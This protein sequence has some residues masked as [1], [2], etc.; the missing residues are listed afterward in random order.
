MT[1]QQLVAGK[2]SE[3]ETAASGG[4]ALREDRALRGDRALHGD[5][6]TNGDIVLHVRTAAHWQVLRSPYR[7]RIFEAVRS[8]G[9]CCIKD[10][11]DA[12]GSSTTALYYHLELLTRAGAIASTVVEPEGTAASRG[13]RRPAL[14]TACGSRIVVAYDAR[15]SRDLRRLATLNRVWLEESQLELLPPET[16]STREERPS[17]TVVMASTVWEVLTEA[18]ATEIRECLDQVETVLAGARERRADQAC[19]L[20]PATHHVAFTMVATTGETLPSPQSS[21]RAVSTPNE[22]A[23]SY[24]P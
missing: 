15:S 2:L 24:K 14:F 12:L 19:A 7:M 16:P 6:A 1:L 3:V 10:L 9:G 13:G 20:K 4:V 5:R 8:T 18:E 11:A 22:L 23:G 17:D 21:A